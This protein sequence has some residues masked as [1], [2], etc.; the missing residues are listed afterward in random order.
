MSADDYQRKFE[1][2]RTAYI[3]RAQG[4]AVEVVALVSSD[5]AAARARLR[6][7]AH[8]IGGTAATFGFGPVSE[9]AGSLEAAIEDGEPEPRI[10]ELADGLVEALAAMRA[11]P[12][13]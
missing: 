2:L 13:F 10:R 6:E 12:S 1:Q 8:K 9:I 3:D 11:A 5:G 7:L 4:N